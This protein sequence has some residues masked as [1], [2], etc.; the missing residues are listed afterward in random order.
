MNVVL[1]LAAGAPGQGAHPLVHVNAA[2]NALAAVLLIIGLARVKQGRE[3]A[4]GKTMM[5]AFAVSSAFLAS[6]ITYHAI[7]GSVPFTH[8]GPARYAYFTILASHVLL[9]VAVPP[10]ALGAMYYG[11]KSLGWGRASRLDPALRA[12]YRERHRRLVR[13]AFP[14][15]LYVSATGVAVY[16]ML[17]HVWPSAALLPKI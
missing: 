15:W 14:V 5:L 13:W 3:T 7:A 10:L 12:A 1:A 11:Q 4:H 6:Y 8:S 2:L 9:A 16:A 17:Y